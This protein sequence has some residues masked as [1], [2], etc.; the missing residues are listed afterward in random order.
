MKSFTYRIVELIAPFAGH[1]NVFKYDAPKLKAFLEKMKTRQK[2]TPPAY[3]SRRFKLE[4]LDF[5][6][7]PCYVV[8]PKPGEGADGAGLGGTGVNGKKK[9]VLFLH[10]G[11]YI[12][13]T[14]WVHW[15][16]VSKL[17]SRLGF[18]VWLPAYP[19]VPWHTMEEITGM[20]L[21]VYRK[22]L[23]SYP[24]ENIIFLGDSAGAALSLTLNHHLKT[25]QAVP[26]PSKLVLI[27][28][29]MLT[30]QDPVILEEMKKIEKRDVLLSMQ[31]MAS[32]IELF[33]LDLSRENYYNAPL[34][35]NFSGFPPMFVFSGTSEIFYPEIVPFIKRVRNVG[36][37]VEFII[38]E[39][40]MHVWPYMPFAA[41]SRRALD[42]VFKIINDA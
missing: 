23:E 39:G 30:E 2:N 33:N 3:I 42:H 7:R 27:S 32:N 13:E 22:M 17:V 6:G 26:M 28:P 36:V 8:S 20:A 29:A 38:G 15:A 1:R 37:P 34:Y 12:Y 4:R 21:L 18:T 25:L 41:E 5:E 24:A 16:A 19:L 14:H 40:M 10:G 11:G 31:F 35:G 9:V